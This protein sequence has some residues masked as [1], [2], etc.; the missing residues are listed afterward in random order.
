MHSADET[1]AVLFRH[2]DVGHDQPRLG[3]RRHPLEVRVGIGRAREGGG[4]E[5]LLAQQVLDHVARVVVVLD[6]QHVRAL[7]PMLQLGGGIG[8]TKAAVQQ[9]LDQP[10]L[11][12]YAA[13]DGIE[14]VRLSG[15][16]RASLP[17]QMGPALD[18]VQG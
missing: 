5:A 13:L 9:A 3:L 8:I 11:G 15:S 2:A 10:G 16:Q 1:V 18:G 14:R 6:H 12:H 7:V 17:E 4:L